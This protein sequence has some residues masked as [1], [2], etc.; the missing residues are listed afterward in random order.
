MR[1]ETV[2]AG[3]FSNHCGM[4]GHGKIR[5][6]MD[7]ICEA[8]DHDYDVI[9]RKGKNPYAKWN[10]ADDRM[11]K[12]IEKLAHKSR[13]TPWKEKLLQDAAW[14]FTKWKEDFLNYGNEELMKEEPDASGFYDEFNNWRE[15][16]VEN[17]IEKHNRDVD[18]AIMDENDWDIDEETKEEYDP[19]RESRKRN[20]EEFLG[21]DTEDE[22]SMP[23]TNYQRGEDMSM[24][25][26]GE[27]RNMGAGG[28]EEGAEQQVTKP[29]HIWR[30]F[31]NTETASL[32]L[33]TTQFLTTMTANYNPRVPFD[34]PPNYVATSLA[35]TGGGTA[36]TSTYVGMSDTTNGWDFSG[37]YLHQVRMT[38]P[39]NCIKAS[40]GTAQLN[41]TGVQKPAW[42]TYFDSK[43]QYYHVI[44]AEWQL[45]ITFG[46]PNNGA[47]SS[48]ARPEAFGYYI[49]W[50]Y[51]EQDDPPLTETWSTRTIANESKVAFDGTTG[52]PQVPYNVVTNTGLGGTG[53]VSLG[54]DDYL[55]MGGWHHKRVMLNATHLTETFIKGRYKFGQCKMDVKTLQPSDAHSADTTAEGWNQ[56]QATPAF[57]EI[58][59]VIIVT[60]ESVRVGA[61]V[62]TPCTIRTEVEYI[63]Q[64]KD[65]QAQYKFPT[66]S[67]A[68][69]PASNNLNTDSVFFSAGA[70]YSD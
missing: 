5:H 7:A 11:K 18:R 23:V 24:Q 41:T 6:L 43:Y 32:K 50:R 19:I 51:T 4:G 42:L 22:E 26:V 2:L 52:E 54:S 63:T 46:V 44:E 59:S 62:Y 17:Y 69:T 67:L 9:T 48:Q 36:S 39:Y 33:L 14:Q 13:K 61:G 60:D 12:A 8:H 20:Y 29:K 68:Q 30:R 3:W 57:P 35:S 45:K 37:P 16:D 25:V 27:Q 66:A 53:V 31:P 70:A 1:Q 34:E 55:R 38:T 28:I 64:F 10:W 56:V 47:G 58:L 65:L 15:G 40:G 49:F 21:S